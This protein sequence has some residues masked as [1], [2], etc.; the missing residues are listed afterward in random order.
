MQRGRK[1][2]HR[3]KL[4][5]EG[6]RVAYNKG[7]EMLGVLGIKDLEVL[8]YRVRVRVMSVSMRENGN[9]SSTTN[10]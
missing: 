7:C 8:P 10:K 6:A 4:P 3:G 1:K 2:A 5:N 9:Q